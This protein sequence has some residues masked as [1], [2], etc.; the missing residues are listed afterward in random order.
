MV[1]HGDSEALVLSPRL[2]VCVG[3]HAR[4]KLDTSQRSLSRASLPLFSVAGLELGAKLKEE[5]STL[6]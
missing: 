2:L 1:L 4:P 6:C 5:N 3:Y